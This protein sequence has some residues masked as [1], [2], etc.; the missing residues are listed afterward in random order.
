MVGFQNILKVDCSWIR[1]SAK[2][3][4]RYDAFLIIEHFVDT[5]VYDNDNTLS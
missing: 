4:S 2:D 5:K 1:K 3:H